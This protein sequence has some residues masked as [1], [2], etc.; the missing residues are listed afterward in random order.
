MQRELFLDFSA[1]CLLGQVLLGHKM[2]LTHAHWYFINGVP[3]INRQLLTNGGES[4]GESK[5]VYILRYF[6]NSMP[7]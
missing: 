1:L 6:L 7:S 4:E 2:H 5:S 3:A